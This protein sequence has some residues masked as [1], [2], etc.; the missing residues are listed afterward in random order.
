MKAPLIA[1]SGLAVG[2]PSNPALTEKLVGDA[3]GADAERSPHTKGKTRAQCVERFPAGFAY[4]RRQERGNN[5]LVGKRRKEFRQVWLKET[6]ASKSA[7]RLA[8]S[9]W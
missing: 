8:R 4:G 2:S 3:Q 9:M 6:N 1:S 7:G 5:D